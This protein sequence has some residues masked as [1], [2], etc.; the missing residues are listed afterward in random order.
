MKVLG[1]RGFVIAG[2]LVSLGWLY[3]QSA[4]VDAD[5]HVRLVGHFEQLRQQDARLGQYVLQARYGLLRNYDPLVTSAHEINQLLLALAQEAGSDFANA[6]SPLGQAY[7]RLKKLY[8]D[9]FTLLEAFKSHASVLRNSRAYLPL[10]V[11]QMVAQPGLTEPTREAL[12]NLLESVLALDENHAVEASSH[13][14]DL[15]QQIEHVMPAKYA[16]EWHSLVAHVKLVLEYQAEVNRYTRDIILSATDTEG[17]AM[18]NAYGAQFTQR[19]VRADRYRLALATLAAALLLYVAWALLALQRA[20]RTLTDSLRELEFQ[21]YALDQHSIVSVADRS[22]KIID[23]NAKFTEISQYSRQELVGQDHR[24]LNSGYHSAE[25]FRTMWSTIG[26]GQ[27]WRGLVRNRCKDGSHYWVDSTIVPFRDDAGKVVRYVSIRTDV[28]DKVQADA[29]LADQRAFYEQITETLGEGLYVQDG[30][31]CCVYLNAEAERLLGWPREQLIG[32]RLHPV[33]HQQRPDGSLLAEADCPI[34][35]AVLAHGHAMLDDQVFVRR[36]GTAFPVALSCRAVRNETGRVASVVVAFTDISVRKQTEQQMQQARETAERAAQVKSDFLANMSHEL[37]TP[38]NG[39]IGMT[40]LAL[41]T[42]LTSDQREY[43]GL[44]KSSA[45]ALLTIIND[46]LDFSKIESGKLSIEVIAFSLESMLRDT[47]KALATRAHD[48][49]LELLLHIAPDVPDRVM[50]DPGRLR[51]VMVNLLGNAIKFTERGEVELSVRCEASATAAATRLRFAVRDTG[52][53]IA[54][55]KFDA[56]FESFSQADTSTTRQY[57]GTGLG[58]TISAQLVS[59]MGGKILLNSASGQGSEFYFSLELPLAKGVDV[60]SY[61]KDGCIVGLPVLAVDDNETNR[62]LLVELLQHWRMRPVAVASA[63]QALLEINRAAQAGQP[64]AL[65]LLD[66]QM[67]DMDGFTLAQKMKQQ[68][69]GVAPI[70]MLTSQAQRGD[71]QRCRD[72]GLAAYLTKPVVASDLLD[73][74]MTTLGAP[75]DTTDVLTRHT[76]REDRQQQ[77]PAQ[78]PLSLLLAEDNAVNQRLASILLG[79]QGHQLQI[80]NNGQEAVQLWQQQRF[81]AVLMDVDMPL[82]NGYEATAQIRALEKDRGG[83]TPIIA[84]TAHAMAGAR[85]ECLA[86]G[87]DGYVSKPLALAALWHELQLVLPQDAA[88]ASATPASVAPSLPVADFDALRQTIGDD[89]AL[90]DELVGLY[91]SDAPQQLQRIRD[92][93]VNKDA[94]A[95]RR[96]AHA[97]RGM[98]G[99]FGAARTMAIAQQLEDSSDDSALCVALADDLERYLLELTSALDARQW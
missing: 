49:G 62:H 52:I 44:V 80:A 16:S 84:M 95:L 25:F 51:Q 77:V 42:N 70:M 41:E 37:R 88:L 11:R 85:E 67:P 87:M 34:S 86:H 39:I 96:A 36:D 32:K 90:Y 35:H 76:L 38:M 73:A 78:R 1:L 54:P 63:E 60:Q 53:G 13:I 45:D 66:V 21:K 64:F 47:M 56:I 2:V 82:M 33:I 31:G 27:V 68:A 46:I 4:Q 7:E 57:G 40:Q 61:R 12:H 74:I 19:Q 83:H 94:L 29:R 43:V 71:V 58:L 81:D 92:A 59:L 6:Q 97:L 14:Q 72:L 28:T 26:H 15:I 23:I 89:R 91:Q 5:A 55:D 93:L 8:A 22:G 20:R 50:G 24:I 9:K 69:I 48:K 79:K 65:A 75:G 10:G 30:H 17:S 3:Q 18:F 98:V 99:V